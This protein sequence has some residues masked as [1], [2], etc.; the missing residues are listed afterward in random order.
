MAGKKN[1]ALTDTL[2][3][4]AGE[5]GA[6]AA[7]EAI[8]R[9]TSAFQ[10]MTATEAY[11]QTERRLW[12]LR[13]LKDKVE[14]DK[15]RLAEYRAGIVRG[16]SKDIVRFSRSG[17]RLDPLEAAEAL[18]EDLEKKIAGDEYEIKLLEDALSSIEGD[19]Y[20]PAVFNKY[21]LQEHDDDI[22]AK[23][24]CN[25]ATVRKNRGRLVRR[26]AVWLYGSTAV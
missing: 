21:L 16:R 11:K 2:I 8:S 13:V 1:P 3:K 17:S 26:I 18:A 10:T 25:P 7:L 14:Y 19:P 12:S 22:A 6:K 24:P 20:Y 23:I 4:L 15:E 5:A 9:N